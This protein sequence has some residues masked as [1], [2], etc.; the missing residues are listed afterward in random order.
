MRCHEALS[1][2]R[3]LLFVPGN[4][5]DLFAKATASEADL[6]IFDL[7]DA[8]PSSDKE[9]ARSAVA[10]WLNAGHLAAVRINGSGTDEHSADLALVGAHEC[11][12]VVPK[13]ESPDDLR[14]AATALTPCSPLV[15]LIETA[16]GVLAA[17]AIARTDQVERLAFGSFDLAAQLGVDPTDRQAM[18]A[19]RMALVLGSAAARLSAPIDGVTSRL[20][21]DEALASET[22]HA[23]SLGFTA[24]LCIHPRQ[25]RTIHN[26]LAPTAEEVDWAKRIVSASN[27]VGVSVIDNSMVDK[28]VIDR[29][30]RVLRN[31]QNREGDHE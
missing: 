6:V 24:R 4:R 25:V 30:T 17:T 23:R 18:Y 13:A 14:F 15:A 12:V 8:V 27:R 20:N 26:A 5:P 19:A 3:S 22:S 2:A 29:A 1:N 16:V 11:I 28:P 10:E 9:L 21:D 31:A 7:E